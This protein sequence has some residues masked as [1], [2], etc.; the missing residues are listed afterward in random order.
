MRGLLSIC[1]IAVAVMFFPDE[2]KAT[3][4][5]GIFQLQVQHSVAPQVVFRNQF[6]HQQQVFAKQFHQQ[7]VL[8]QQVPVHQQRILVQQVPVRHQKVLVQQVPV[9]RQK[10]LVQQVRPQATVVRSRTVQRSRPLFRPFR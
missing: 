9:H 5:H 4:G 10:V 2:S 7:R 6:V 1:L 8:V 3:D